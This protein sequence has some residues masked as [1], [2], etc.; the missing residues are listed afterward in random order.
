MKCPECG[1]IIRLDVDDGGDIYLA[2]KT[3]LSE[4]YADDPQCE[5][6]GTLVDTPISAKLEA[7]MCEMPQELLEA[8]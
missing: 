1:G 2:C 3:Q 4:I 8:A 6:W 7:A 5:W